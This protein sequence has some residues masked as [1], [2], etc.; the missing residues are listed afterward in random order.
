MNCIG[1]TVRRLREAKGLYQYELADR[2]DVTKA[3]ISRIEN[4]EREPSAGM[5]VAISKAL[6]CTVDDLLRA[7]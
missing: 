2:C 7:G 4:G 3:C 6:G 5:L 1:I